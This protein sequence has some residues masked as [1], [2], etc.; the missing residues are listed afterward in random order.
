[1]GADHQSAR[2]ELWG[3]WQTSPS[4][5]LSLPS[6]LGERHDCDVVSPSDSKLVVVLCGGVTQLPD[7]TLW[8]R[9]KAGAPCAIPMKT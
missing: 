7:F 4:L 3:G 5:L 1:M 2:V 6:G 9:M 8:S